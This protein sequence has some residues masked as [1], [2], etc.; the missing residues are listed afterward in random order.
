MDIT[1][2]DIIQLVFE[3]ANKIYV[4]YHSDISAKSQIRNLVEIYGKQG[5][6]RLRAEKDMY[7]FRMKK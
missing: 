5:L 4:L 7:L 2:K 6:D 1:D 3:S